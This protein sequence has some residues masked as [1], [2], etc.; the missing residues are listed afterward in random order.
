MKNNIQINR[1][2]FTTVLFFTICLAAIY[3]S[4]II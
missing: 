4:I 1:A 2:A 3:K